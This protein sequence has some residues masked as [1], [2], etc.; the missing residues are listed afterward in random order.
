MPPTRTR[1]RTRVGARRRFV[2]EFFTN[3][4]K[5]GS[6]V[7]SS[8]YLASAILRDLKLNSFKG[9]FEYGP[10]TGVFTR[11]LYNAMDHDRAKLQLVEMSP[12]F[13]RFLVDAFPRATVHVMPASQVGTLNLGPGDIDLVI[14]SLPFS[15]IPWDE[16]EKTI[17]ETVKLLPK[18]GRFRTFL[19]F[20]TFPIPKNVKLFELLKASFSSV[21][22]WA[23]WRNF[24]P[25]IVIECVK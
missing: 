11:V 8:R 3:P 2:R 20:H 7:P 10:G 12:D 25:A 4:L 18:G 22:T 23:E 9:I 17:L 1:T 13:A 16:T 14:S 5:V 21:I 6:L 15:V 24:P 19:Y